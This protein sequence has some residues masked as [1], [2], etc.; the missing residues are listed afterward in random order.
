MRPIDSSLSLTDLTATNTTPAE[1]GVNV[2]GFTTASLGLGVAARA[3]I[4]N[5]LAARVPVAIAEVSLP[6][7]RSGADNTYAY[8]QITDANRERLP[9]P[10]TLVAVNPDEAA[11]VWRQYARWFAQTYNCIMPFWEL[12]VVPDQWVPHLAGYDAVL[13]AT[14]HIAGAVKNVVSTAV[15]RFPLC[16]NV[17]DV[18][19]LRRSDFG[20]PGD[21]FALAATWDTNSGLGRK[22]SL[23]VL[24]AFT[25]AL[26]LGSDSVLV[27]KTNGET[28][29][30]RFNRAI[31]DL[32]PDR[33]IVISD[34][35]PY[36]DLL[37][38][39]AAC[40]AF[41]SL[42]RAE[43][44]GLGL[45]EAMLLGRP[46]IAT[47]WSGNMDFMDES[48]ALIVSF[49]LTPVVD[50]HPAY[51]A[52]H[53]TQRQLWAE[54]DILDAARHIHRLSRDARLC[55]RLGLRGQQRMIAYRDRWQTDGPLLLSELY[56]AH[57]DGPA[58]VA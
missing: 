22:N 19:D 17:T 49:T 1:F 3:T 46:V 57:L 50:V 36:R 45:Q 12:P 20:I 5:L 48:C 26:E 34:L 53:L 43:G 58:R 55:E 14:E 13:A 4:A 25:A 27:L 24:R 23:G 9:H 16:A 6:D 32:P 39:Y 31:R 37:G 29:D 8:L 38:M 33:V 30:P 51:T 21:R 47:G 10:L 41:I 28:P 54:P 18:A 56:R 7:G 52:P 2:I 42:H 40:D 35:L 44:L 15:R 11:A